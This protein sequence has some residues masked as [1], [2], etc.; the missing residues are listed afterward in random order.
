MFDVN[1]EFMVLDQTIKEM[2][3]FQRSAICGYEKMKQVH[4]SSGIPDIKE[5]FLMAARKGA[6]DDFWPR[7][8]MPDFEPK[9]KRFM[10]QCHKVG[11]RI[12][13]LLESKLDISKGQ[14]TDCNT[15]WGDE[16]KCVLR[17]LH[18]PPT[19]SFGDVPAN[20]W[21]AAPHT[22]FALLTLLFQIPGE[23]GLQCAQRHHSKDVTASDP[24]GWQPVP[25]I[26]GAITCNI[27]DMLMR[28]S[29]DR[30]IS[31]LHRVVMPSGEDA[32]KSRYSM[33]FFLQPDDSALI[34]SDKYETVTAREMIQGRVRAYWPTTDKTKF[35]VPDKS[36]R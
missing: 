1:R 28:W 15:L 17:L 6:M 25:P 32:A 23:D 29:S 10:E 20:Q 30:L 8:A 26:T 5:N 21:R 13:S 14:I 11:T 19:R 36:K 24:L 27:G 2:S 22:D 12:L 18:Y 31:N 16:G 7:E 4:P 34:E 35:H 9:S 33:A 3:K